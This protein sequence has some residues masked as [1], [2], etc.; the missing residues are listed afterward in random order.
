MA[1][2]TQHGPLYPAR[3]FFTQNGPFTQTGT[4]KH[5]MVSIRNTVDSASLPL[6]SAKAGLGQPLQGSVSS[7]KVWTAASGLAPVRL[8]ALAGRPTKYSSVAEL[9]CVESFC[10]LQSIVSGMSVAVYDM[11]AVIVLSVL[12][13]DAMYRT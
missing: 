13:D 11:I 9:S 12:H 10:K 4:V 2:L 8:R 3:P 6:L 1:L 7:F 5:A